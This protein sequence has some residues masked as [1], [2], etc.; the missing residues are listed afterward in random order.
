MEL[1]K[2]LT[3]TDM[4]H[5]PYKG[6]AG[7]LADVT[8]GQIALAMDNIPVYLPQARAGKIRALGVSSSQRTQA[9]PEIPTV[10]EAGVPGFEALSWFGLL[11]PARTPKAVVDKLAAETARILALPEV[12]ERIT[13]LGAQPIGSTPQEYARFIQAETAKWE[14]V[15]RAAGV[16]LE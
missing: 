1:F 6:S 4:V 11:A 9:A 12:R 14:K 15:I 3:G 2:T 7:V 16:K 5:V 10:A 8:A 13:G